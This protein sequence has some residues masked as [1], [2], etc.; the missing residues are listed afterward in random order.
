M[1]RFF[2]WGLFFFCA[3]GT[4]L[5]QTAPVLDPRKFTERRI[6]IRQMRS[7]DPSCYVILKNGQPQ[8][9]G[10]DY[11]HVFFYVPEGSRGGVFHLEVEFGFWRPGDVMQV[12]DRCLN[13]VSAPMTIQ[14]DYAYLTIPAGPGHGGNW[15]DPTSQ[16]PPYTALN[17]ELSVGQCAPVTLRSHVL[18]PVIVGM[19]TDVGEE[20][21]SG[22]F[23]LN[24][25]PL[26]TIPMTTYT[27]GD[28]TA[29]QWGSTGSLTADGYL[30]LETIPMYDGKTPLTLEY[31]HNGMADITDFWM[32]VGG[33]GIQAIQNNRFQVIKRN[34][35]GELVEE[36]YS[37]DFSQARYRIV[38]TEN[39]YQVWVN[40]QLISTLDRFVIYYTEAGELSNR[41]PMPYGSSVTFQPQVSGSQTVGV[42]IDGAVTVRQRLHIASPLSVVADGTG[43]RCFGE[44]SGQVILSPTGGLAPFTYTQLG[45]AG[46]T[47]AQFG[48]LAAGTYTFRVQDASGCVAD[49]GASV[50]SPVLLE[51][52]AVD[53]VATSCLG[54]STGQVTLAAQG[55]QGGYQYR[56]G[57]SDFQG[58]NQIGGLPAGTQT[59]EVRDQ[60]GCIGQTT[61]TLGYRSA[62]AIEAKSSRAACHGTATGQLAIES[63]RPSSGT[64]RYSLNQMDYQA[65]PIFSQL[66]AG[67]YQVWA[68]DAGCQYHLTGLQIQEPTPLVIV[69]NGVENARCYGETSGRWEAQAQGGT[70]PYQFSTN[71][72]T[73]TPNDTFAWTDLGSGTYKLWA[74]DAEGCT[75]EQ[76]QMISEPTQLL[77]TLTENVEVTCPGTATGRL[78][79][80]ASG[81]NGGF[82]Y[83]LN[84]QSSALSR[85]ENLPAGVYQLRAED[86]RGCTSF[87]QSEIT[88]PPTLS[89]SASV[90]SQ[91]ACF[92][93]TTGGLALQGTGGT[94]PYQFSIGGDFQAGTLFAGLG[95]AAYPLGI[96]DS[97]GCRHEAPS[98]QVIDQ[99]SLLHVQ[100]EAQAVRCPAGQDGQL[101]LQG[102]GGQGGYQYSTDGV[103][104]QNQGIFGS[105][106]AGTYTFWVRDQAGCQTTTT[107]TLSEP[108]PLRFQDWV[109]E[110]VRC[111]GGATGRLK[112]QASGGTAPYSFS[113]QG[114]A[115]QTFF[116]LDTL[117]VGTYQVAGRD[118]R[119]CSF[120]SEEKGI[121]EPA[122]LVISVDDVQEVRCFGGQDGQ[123]RLRAVGGVS[124]FEF[125]LQGQGFSVAATFFNLS[126]Q[127]YTFVGR[128]GNGCTQPLRVS[129]TQPSAYQM[130]VQ[131]SQPATCHGEATGQIAVL[132]QGGT[133]PYQAWIREDTLRQV[134]P[135][136]LGLGAADYT[137]QGMDARGC[138]FALSDITIGQPQPI[139]LT[140]Q[141]VK[142]VDCEQY[143]RG[144]IQVLA[145]GSHGGFG[146]Q[147]AGTTT[148]GSPFPAQFSAEGI[149]DELPTGEFHIVA[150]DQQGCTMAQP[151]RIT[152]Q[153]TSI[154]FAVMAQSPTQCQQADG[155]IQ[156][157]D[158]VG[159]RGNYT[160]ILNRGQLGD[161]RFS[162]LS[163]GVYQVTVT[164]SLCETRQEVRLEA[165]GTPQVVYEARPI[166]CST[167][168]AA[169]DLS[170]S[171]Q[172]GEMYEVQWPG[173]SFGTALSFQPMPPGISEIQVR[174]TSTGCLVRIALDIQPQNK[175]NLNWVE[176][177][178]LVC[179]EQPKGVLEVRGSG[180]LQYRLGAGPWGASPR[181]TSLLAGSYTVFAQN[182][183][184]CLDSI[185]ASLGQPTRLQAQT[186]VTANLCHGDSTGRIQLLA[187]GGVGGYQFRLG[188]QPWQESPQFAQLKAGPYVVYLQD[189]NGCQMIVPTDIQEPT[190]VQ[191][192]TAEVI[193]VRCFGESNGEI[194]LEAMGGTPGYQFRLLGEAWQSQGRFAGFVVGN[195][196]FEVQDA[197]QCRQEVRVEV[198]QPLLLQ[199]N[200]TEQVS[201]RC[202]EG[203][204]GLLDVRAQGGNG[205]YHYQIGN[206]AWQSSPRFLGLRQGAYQ[207]EVRDGKGCLAQTDMA[208]L[209]HPAVLRAEVSKQ[210]PRCFGESS[211]WLAWQI[212]GGV[213]P[214]TLSVDNF[215]TLG[216]N[217]NRFRWDDVAAGTYTYRV[218]DAQQCD[219]VETVGLPQ[220]SAVGL[221]TAIT[222]VLCF[223]GATGQ[224]NVVGLGATPPYTF[225]LQPL[226]SGGPTFQSNSSFTALAAQAYEVWVR[227][228]QGCQ[229]SQALE[230]PQPPPLTLA[231]AQ[232]DSVRCF[233][234]SNGQFEVKAT[235]GMPGYV[236]ALGTGGFQSASKFERL[237]AGAYRVQVR[238]MNQCTATLPE[239][240]LAQPDQLDMR[241]VKK[242]N[243]RCVGE[244]NGE[245][246]LEALGGNGLSQFSQDQM[247]FQ[248]EA[249]F[250][251]LKA[252]AY[253]FRVRDWKGCTA[254]MPVV[255][256]ERPSPLTAQISFAP[257]TCVGD[258][259]GSLQILPTGGAGNYQAMLW[260][261]DLPEE[262]Q[263]W[264]NTAFQ[265][266]GAGIYALQV[267]DA[268]GCVVNLTTRI[269]SPSPLQR[270]T[271]HSS[272]LDL[273]DVCAKE[274]VTLTAGN[275]GQRYFWSHNGQSLSTET[276]SLRV[277]EPGEYSVRVENE[278]GCRVSQSIRITH[279]PATLAIDFLIPSEVY[280]GDTIVCLDITRPIPQAWEWTY[281][282][283]AQVMVN[284][285]QRLVTTVATP[286]ESIYKLA[287]SDGT[288]WYEK[289]QT[290]RVVPRAVV[291]DDTP[292]IQAVQI[293]PNPSS[294]RFQVEVRLRRPAS[295]EIQ[296]IRQ[297]GGQVITTQ[298]GKG[299][300][301]YVWTFDWQVPSGIYVWVIRAE[302]E[303]VTH[304][305]IIQR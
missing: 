288:C 102:M 135:R 90:V 254:S 265:G 73:Y 153:N 66:A 129:M 180:N 208:Q 178:S 27:S 21:T 52:L 31:T 8:Q 30:R 134:Q 175:G 205:G 198:A 89:V 151:V 122:A 228:A 25:Q 148:A 136:F 51:L 284:D 82:T 201:P 211:G 184:G 5:A 186:E 64:P 282:A 24:G 290:V 182:S 229:F 131:D 246:L 1:K 255:Q 68:E 97:R 169:I 145:S 3:L 96:Q 108:A 19:A 67:T 57:A 69:T 299:Q 93:Q 18:F 200:Y 71:G 238:D 172:A 47:T 143:R 44:S 272:G 224:V 256:L 248:S 263:V 203:S 193:P 146:Y 63:L 99:P 269:P 59:F 183:V 176:R 212:S 226:R 165:P 70:A 56:Q 235:G 262:K 61:A 287:V 160:F 62:W 185:R 286:G 76:L 120:V 192:L 291:V 162:G 50:S 65:S 300:S 119:G 274:W 253:V 249:H 80:E 124:P 204:D 45:L 264:Q 88:Q 103:Q 112:W 166:A 40:D 74:R 266:L 281:P 194:R 55:G 245:V 273:I 95:A 117:R 92:G 188:N 289:E 164:D 296:G 171:S 261:R 234:E 294:G 9:E 237:G 181:F 36:N 197:H 75:T 23:R 15:L 6:S 270:P 215:P 85:W 187:S 195:Y 301:M 219:L 128:D 46:Q 173:Q 137:V 10:S 94:P 293:W 157:Q 191:L 115:Y 132:H 147:L 2:W 207:I 179:H 267:T 116:S 168:E 34:Y 133:A 271:L 91:I 177:T 141:E 156:I 258:Q 225:A 242:Q 257:P 33:I 285:G 14:D 206:Q 214:Y 28:P 20:R 260:L 210:E 12:Q 60:A 167:A 111:Q 22:N 244:E 54:Q 155:V 98:P 11:R 100:V 83:F 232:L 154:R 199:V 236:F 174:A 222:P 126:A 292:L 259:N 243:P 252:G 17:T 220:P 189:Q 209:V 152:A 79:A 121:S 217:A 230:V 149:F 7:T 107:A 87:I 241:L 110:D 84:G 190:P 278:S 39:Q 37:G 139:Q 144:R 113:I 218:R 268:L 233:G 170:I 280:L 223:G 81:S 231:L 303:Q 158:V 240:R 239:I 43:V 221:Q 42:L 114:S 101:T 202:F 38:F 123:I 138:R 49:V 106:A 163:A 216:T 140:W 118:A 13:E 58:N 275:P 32:F 159:G 298:Q 247:A 304:R 77:W 251:N 295:V 297:V 302:N 196:G 161:G 130:H 29:F 142:A 48:G 127:D 227:D 105:R 283:H 109:I 35:L 104:F 41:D 213:G 4:A 16:N 277:R 250:T 276:S 53:S 279:R 26:G 72:S 86:Q 305:F 150:T 125:A 78:V